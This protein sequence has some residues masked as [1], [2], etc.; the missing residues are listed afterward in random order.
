MLFHLSSLSTGPQYTFWNSVTQ[1][2]VDYIIA[3]HDAADY[4]QRCF[5]HKP[6]PLNNSDDLP[7]SAVLRAHSAT[8]ASP[9]PSGSQ[10]INWVKALKSS[11]LDAYQKQVTSIVSPL[12]G[13]SY[14]SPEE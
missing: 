1:T 2:T 3:S 5:T 6:A 7:I 14:N 13:R 11:Q 4:I 10:K 8:T 9:K 12:L